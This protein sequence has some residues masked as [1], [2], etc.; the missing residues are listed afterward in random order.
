M[1]IVAAQ[2]GGDV[3]ALAG[4]HAA[5]EQRCHYLGFEHENRGYRP[6]VTLAR[7]RKPPGANT[8]QRMEEVCGA[9][10]PGPGFCVNEMV[11][12]ES[13]LRAEGARYAVATQFSLAK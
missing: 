12:M 1:R 7:A 9:L 4:V 5:V 8:R 6:H 2:M 13:R 11:L 10:W 3:K